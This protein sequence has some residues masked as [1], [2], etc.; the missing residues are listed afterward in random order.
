MSAMRHLLPT[1]LALAAGLLIACSGDAGAPAAAPV[2]Q[3]SVP[4]DEPDPPPNPANARFNKNLP[5][6]G[7]DLPAFAGVTLDGESLDNG[8]LEGRT[9]LITL[10]FYG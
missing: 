8:D 7:E 1:A 4:Y 10:W 9:A 6:K 3:P 5:K 2:T